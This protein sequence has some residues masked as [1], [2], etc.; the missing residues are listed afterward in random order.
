MTMRW[1]IRNQIMFPLLAAAIVSLTA[2]GVVNAVLAGRRTCE[3][4]E[5]QLRQVIGVLTT[6]SFPLTNPVLRQM[7]ELSSA[8]FVLTDSANL[9]TASTLPEA[10]HIPQQAEISRIQDV[11]LGPSSEIGGQWYFHTVV[12]LPLG[13][14]ASRSGVLHVLFPQ[15]EYR[16][17]W[18]QAFVPAFSVGAVTSLILAAVAWA[19]AS[20]MGRVIAQLREEVVRI[21]RGDFRGVELP[22]V[23]DEIRDLSVAV[24]RT[25]EM[26]DEYEAQVRRSEQMRT[27]TVLGASIAHQLRN[28][29]TGCRL[30]LDLHASECSAAEDSECLDVGKRQLRL[31]ES[32][33]QRFLRVGKAPA[34]M[35]VRDVDL[36]NVVE[37]VLQLVRPA[38]HHAGVALTCRISSQQLIVRGD[39]EALIQVVLNLLLNAIEAAQQNGIAQADQGR[40]VVELALTSREVAELAIADSGDGP[41]ESVADSLF[42]PFATNKPEGAG[43]GLS[44]VKDIVIGHGG[45]IHW[46]RINEM[47]R[48]CFELPLAKDIPQFVRTTA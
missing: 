24:N 34:Q 38:A 5:Q 7:R 8:E 45:R 44:V 11:E 23:D 31:M 42:E 18:R 9:V 32:Q 48:F 3:H 39:E 35:V 29:V 2:V 20:R 15:D 21:A 46:Q 27:L 41:A 36:G 28:A 13:S 37:E 14:E 26:L 4:V 22:S 43:L 12:K 19:L 6:S 10:A 17:A 16:K 40:V 33:L 30:A 47:T 1:P 25:A